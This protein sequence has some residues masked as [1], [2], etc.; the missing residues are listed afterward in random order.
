MLEQWVIDQLN[1]LKGEKLIIL[2]PEFRQPFIEATL[3]PV[4]FTLY[5]PKDPP[6]VTG[7]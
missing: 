1:P 5:S 6:D 4:W 7:Q 3:E 2:T